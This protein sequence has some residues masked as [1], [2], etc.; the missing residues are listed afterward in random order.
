LNR[1]KF[2]NNKSLTKESDFSTF[3]NIPNLKFIDEKSEK[4]LKVVRKQKNVL[5]D[6]SLI[7]AK[8]RVK[9]TI[10]HSTDVDTVNATGI[11][12]SSFLANQSINKSI[13][14]NQN[15][16][17]S[18]VQPDPSFVNYGNSSISIED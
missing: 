6:S 1:Y 18:N 16:R 4:K 13:R 14:Y 5:Q 15:H 3:G 10:N 12:H 17:L 11:Q 7:S 2:V 9:G 8:V